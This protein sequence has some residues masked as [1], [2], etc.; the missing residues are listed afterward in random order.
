MQGAVVPNPTLAPKV[1]TL[2]QVIDMCWNCCTV[3]IKLFL[4]SANLEGGRR[5][6]FLILQGGLSPRQPLIASCSMYFIGTDEKIGKKTISNYETAFG[7]GSLS[8]FCFF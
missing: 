4:T 1:C 7:E 2:L 8:N 6:I 5:P 3:L